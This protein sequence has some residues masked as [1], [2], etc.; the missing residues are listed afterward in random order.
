MKITGGHARGR[1]IASPPDSGVR[2]TSARVRE[3]LFSVVGHALDDVRVLDAFG[4][5]GLLS[6]EAWSRGAQVVTVERAP[7]V[8]RRILEEVR[9]F[10]AG[11]DVRLGDV[12]SLAP[13]LGVFGLV[14]VDPPY[15]APVI[16]ILE[17]LA[18]CCGNM[19]VLEADAATTVP[20]RVGGLLAD[21]VR[22]YGGTALHVFRSSPCV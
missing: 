19:L 8:H 9:R 1:V 13:S 20:A 2:P 18:P 14:L 15:A 3:A 12:V 21:P 22:R 6:F 10:G 4:G 11:I 17:A 7:A 5:S 16:P